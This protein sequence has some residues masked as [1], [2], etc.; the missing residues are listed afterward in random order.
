[1]SKTFVGLGSPVTPAP[2][3]SWSY[4]PA[5]WRIEQ[6]LPLPLSVNSTTAVAG[7]VLDAADFVSGK[8]QIVS[9][10]A[11]DAGGVVL[12]QSSNDQVNWQTESTT[13]VN[14]VTANYVD[15]TTFG[16]Y[17]RVAMAHAGA[18]D[19]ELSAYVLIQCR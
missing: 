6:G 19:D 7:P 14:S 3:T 18:A 2:R 9:T 4:N 8:A 13:T 1:M 10:A 12:I 11:A 15:L 16:R 17:L 5:D